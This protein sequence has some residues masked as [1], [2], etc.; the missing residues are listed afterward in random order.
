M[1]LFTFLMYAYIAL[2]C[3]FK[4]NNNNS[5]Y[6]FKCIIANH[7]TQY[8]ICLIYLFLIVLFILFYYLNI[9]FFAT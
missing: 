3:L 9:L 7:D 8:I 6:C 1:I 4:N 2:L 5:F